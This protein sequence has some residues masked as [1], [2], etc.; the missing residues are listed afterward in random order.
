MRNLKLLLMAFAMANASSLI[1]QIAWVR[2]LMY[3]FG[4]SVYA[5]SAVLT[6]FMSGLALGSL[7][8]GHLADRHQNTARLFAEIQLGI[9]AFGVFTVLLLDL[10]PN[11]YLLIHKLFGESF[12]FYEIE[13]LLAFII[14]I[15][16]TSLIG[17]MFPA[18][19]RLYAREVKEVGEKISV[20]YTADTLGAGFGSFAGGFLLVPLLGIDGTIIAASIANIVV[21]SLIYYDEISGPPQVQSS[22]EKRTRG[23]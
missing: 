22:R 12:F 18:M 2:S 20:L 1:F 11:S 15:V 5:I 14:L 3:V 9:G 10:L 21:G 16:P 8:F 19:S 4:S 7:I 6:V 13:F 17:G 23:K